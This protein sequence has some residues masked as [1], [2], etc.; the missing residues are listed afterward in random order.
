[1]GVLSRA[2]VCKDSRLYAAAG[3][4]RPQYSRSPPIHPLT[5][6][7]PLPPLHISHSPPLL[8]LS[9]VL[10]A[11]LILNPGDGARCSRQLLQR[12][13]RRSTPWP[14][15]AL[16]T[17]CLCTILQCLRC[18]FV[19]I[20]RRYGGCLAQPIC[21]NSAL[22][23]AAFFGKLSSSS[24]SSSITWSPIANSASP[25]PLYGACV[26]SPWPHA[27][28]EPEPSY[29][30]S[31]AAMMTGGI[32]LASA[33]VPSLPITAF[34]FDSPAALASIGAG[35]SSARPQPRAFSA[36]SLIG[37]SDYFM[38]CAPSSPNGFL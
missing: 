2:G 30:Q 8:S 4:T 6:F 35:A 36:C 5:L 20:K 24:S 29:S 14:L 38:M 3:N 1:M 9:P 12:R 13:H 31:G 33:F 23:S 18:I 34:P 28:F 25:A 21:N 10:H 37:I 15:Q 22:S 19:T 11:D 16:T 27:S 32:T 17:P 26:A 7:P